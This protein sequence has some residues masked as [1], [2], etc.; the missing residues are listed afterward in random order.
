MEW[1]PIHGTAMTCQ[2]LPLRAQPDVIAGGKSMAIPQKTTWIIMLCLQDY[3]WSTFVRWI[4]LITYIFIVYLQC[5]F[6]CTIAY[7]AVLFAVKSALPGRQ[8]LKYPAVKMCQIWSWADTGSIHIVYRW[9]IDTICIVSNF[10]NDVMLY[11]EQ[12]TVEF[13]SK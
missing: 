3:V 2:V 6:T 12:I 11:K 4:S 1:R 10:A 13:K 7:G 9:N 5:Y 8:M